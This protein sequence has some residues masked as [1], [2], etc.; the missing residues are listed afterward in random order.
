MLKSR[1][2]P[3]SIKN[4]SKLNIYST[5]CSQSTKLRHIFISTKKTRNELLF[6]KKRL[7]SIGTMLKIKYNFGYWFSYV[8]SAIFAIQIFSSVY[9]SITPINHITLS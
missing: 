6:I 9:S 5:M 4:Y 3:V 2:I 1:T 7:M 8:L